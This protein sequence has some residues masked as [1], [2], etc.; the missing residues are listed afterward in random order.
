MFTPSQ[1]ETTIRPN[2]FTTQDAGI[3]SNAGFDKFWNRILFSKHSNTTLQLFGK[4]LGY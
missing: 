1:I 3:N 4:A 2:T